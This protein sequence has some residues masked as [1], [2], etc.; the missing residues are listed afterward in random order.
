[1]PPLLEARQLARRHPDGQG[2]LLRDASLSIHPGDRVAVAGPSGS[3]KTLLLRAMALLDPL[4]GGEVVWRG[5]TVRRDRVP[6]FRRQ[7][8]YLHQRAALAGDSVEAVLREPFAFC[9]HRGR[10]FQRRR[11]VELLGR[12]GRDEDFLEKSPGDL[13]G[14]EAQI[15]ALVR[16]I[17]L[18]PVLLLLD[19]PTAALDARTAQAVEKL[20]DDWAAEGPDERAAVWVSH[21]ADQARRVGRRIARIDGGRLSEGDRHAG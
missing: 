12:L 11:A 19:E 2:W 6:L 3:G 7:A 17:Q 13:S 20:V 16:A 10:A 14:G 8:I 15:A 9:A 5:Q 21:D 4:D 1:M 18:D